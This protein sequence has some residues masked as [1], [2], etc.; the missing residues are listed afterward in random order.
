V[1]AAL[2]NLL[3]GRL[4]A[5]AGWRDGSLNAVRLMMGLAH[6]NTSA[7]LLQIDSG[8]PYSHALQSRPSGD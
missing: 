3:Y 1:R 8:G 5:G 6:F 2:L 7:G 4:C